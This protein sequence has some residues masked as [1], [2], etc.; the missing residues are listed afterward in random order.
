MSAVQHIQDMIQ[1]RFSNMI[2][3]STIALGELTLT[4][5]PEHLLVLC[6]LLRDD[7]A[8]RFEQLMDVCGIDYLD[9]G[10][11]EWVTDQATG[12]GFERAANREDKLRVLPAPPARF[13]VAYH[14]LSVTYNHRVR[15]KVYLPTDFPCVDSVIT[16]WPSADWFEREAFDLFGILFNGHPDLRRILTDYGF[17]GHPFRKDF[18]L[19]GNVEMRYDATQGRVVYEPVSIPPRILVPKVIRQ[20][21]R[22]ID[23]DQQR[24]SS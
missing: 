21:S 19:I 2:A 9:Y 14:L 22:Y 12:T 18:P 1:T 15:L 16:I 23:T 11:S 20:D 7:P 13:A 10:L 17:V 24:A 6:K 8:L 3:D 5:H 4:V